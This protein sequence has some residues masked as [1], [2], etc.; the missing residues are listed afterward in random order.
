MG[1]FRV[2]SMALVALV[3]VTIRFVGAQPSPST[4]GTLEPHESGIEVVLA[5]IE[6][7]DATC[8]FRKD[9]Q[10]LRNIAQAES[11]N[12]DKNSVTSSVGGIWRVSQSVFAA[13][14][15]ASL[16]VYFS[17]FPGAFGI[18]W[19][20]ATW[21][22]LD[23]PLYSA[24]AARLAIALQQQ[25]FLNTPTSLDGK[26]PWSVTAQSAI[27]KAAFQKPES[28]SALQ[29]LYV[30]AVQLIR[31]AGTASDICA[32]RG[33]WKLPLSWTC[34]Q[35]R[36]RQLQP[37]E[38]VRQ[39]RR[40]QFRSRSGAESVRGG[41]FDSV[42]RPIIK[43]NDYSNKNSLINAI[44]AIP[45]TGGGTE[46][47]AGL[48]ALRAVV[49]APGNGVRAGRA[50]MAIVLTDGASNSPAQTTAAAS[51]IHANKDITVL[52]V[53]IGAG[54]IHSSYATELGLIA[55]D[56]KCQNLYQLQE[57]HDLVQAFAL[58]IQQRTC[59]ATAQLVVESIVTDGHG[60]QNLPTPVSVTLKPDGV[61]FTCVP[62][63]RDAFTSLV[64]TGREG[65][66]YVYVSLRVRKPSAS[67]NDFNHRISAGKRE[68]I[69]FT[70]QMIAYYAPDSVGTARVCM[71]M[72]NKVG[73]RS[74]G[75]FSADVNVVGG[76]FK[77]CGDVVNIG[78][79][80]Q[81]VDI[82]GP[83][84]YQGVAIGYPK[85]LRCQW[86]I[87]GPPNHYL[88]IE[89]SYFNVTGYDLNLAS[90]ELS[91]CSEDADRLDIS[92]LTAGRSGEE[93]AVVC[94]NRKRSSTS[95]YPSF[96]SS[97][98]TSTI[99]FLTTKDAEP[100]YGFNMIITA[101]P[102]TKHAV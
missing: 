9:K 78:S 101:L 57:F 39:D 46:T 38:G 76:V 88:L 90:R 19:N 41:P 20:T 59:D 1:F 48:N 12:G 60:S 99:T 80:N 8:I 35:H 22:D 6:K 10:M 25:E 21:Q 13:T 64:V 69:K 75:A 71:G 97:G 17:R 31:S 93:T 68:T 29:S 62:I 44:S 30:A 84:Y 32:T 82:P 11:N 50:K 23:K 66:A 42:V 61:Y 87:R 79:A 91:G 55:S 18:N 15:S 27:W 102:E 81:P 100:G 56:P 63:Q 86:K 45:Y 28:A 37:D 77:A 51:A 73:A 85:D 36:A 7:I 53:G 43:L 40:Q 33:V 4:D 98:S 72:H 96:E 3:A 94:A 5:S 24:L 92:S 74:S 47:A 2:A 54:V 58:E 67:Q 16:S 52:S 14:K 34:P 49:F 26:L 95:M 89:F 65:S 83:G 70:P